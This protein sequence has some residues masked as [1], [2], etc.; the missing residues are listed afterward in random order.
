MCYVLWHKESAF[1]FSKVNAEFAV[2]LKKDTEQG[3]VD[4]YLEDIIVFSRTFSDHL[5]NLQRVFECLKEAGLKL[6][7]EER[8]VLLFRSEVLGLLVTPSGFKPNIKNIEAVKNFPVPTTLKELSQFLGLTS[9]YRRFVKGYSSLAQ[10]LYALTRKD[11]LYHWTTECESA[12]NH[13]KCCLITAPELVYPDFDRN[14][15]LKMDASILGLGVIL[16]QVQDVGKLHPLTYCCSLSKSEK[17]Y[18]VT[19][20]ETL[21]VV[22]GITH[23][24]YYLYGHQ[25]TVYTDHA[26]VKAVLETPNLTGKHARWWSKIHGSGVGRLEIIHRA[27]KENWHADA[28]S[29]QP[30]LLAPEEEDEELEVQVAKIASSRIPENIVDLLNKQPT[31]DTTDS[32]SFSSQQLA[33]PELILYLRDGVLPEN[34]Q[35]AQEV[36]TLAQRFTMSDNML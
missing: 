21:A 3:F 15:V 9:H 34:G 30:N 8:Q 7:Q 33:D 4:V 5:I 18:L 13:L 19:E 36:I 23:F 12:F 16:S 20:L 26:A 25:V 6:N 1:C 28:L 27:G 2:G 17:N 24:R 32:N 29:H 11:A 31:D 10:L 14:F 35:Q 22:W